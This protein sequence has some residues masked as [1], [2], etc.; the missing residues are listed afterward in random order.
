MTPRR[1]VSSG[2]E[3]ES[4][5]GYHRAVA[6]G[7]RSWVSGTT[8]ASRGEVP[9][10]DA[11]AQARAAFGIALDALAQLDFSV[12][13]VVRTR[14]YVTDI[15]D[16][17]QVGRVHGEVFDGVGPTATMVEVSALIDPRLKVEV[18]L[19]AVA[20]TWSDGGVVR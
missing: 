14:M 11:A 2:A 8:A 19:E 3:W 6:V 9:V 5:Y 4:T 16:A 1:S 18:E 10:P 15:A 7:G 12:G 13:D 17:D 20:S